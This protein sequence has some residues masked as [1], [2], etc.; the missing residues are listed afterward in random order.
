MKA[1]LAKKRDDGRGGWEDKEQCSAEFLSQLLREHVEKGDPLDVGILAM[2]LHQRGEVIT[3]KVHHSDVI[4]AEWRA[5]NKV[6]NYINTL[7]DSAVKK[8]DI[9]NAVMDMRPDSYLAANAHMD[10]RPEASRDATEFDAERVSGSTGLPA[11]WHGDHTPTDCLKQLFAAYKANQ[12]KSSRHNATDSSYKSSAVK[13]RF[14]ELATRIR[15]GD[16][17]FSAVVSTVNDFDM[18]AEER[19][20]ILD[21][22]DLAA[23]KG[24]QTKTRRRIIRKFS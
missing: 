10:K 11:G 13:S 18:S 19:H 12:P 9:C 7:E 4:S 1:K 8:S 23:S 20:T 14:S 5:F 17:K 24:G 16:F 6:L 22:L 2:M 3:A 21:A 15:A